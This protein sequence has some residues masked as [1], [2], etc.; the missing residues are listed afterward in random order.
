[1]YSLFSTSCGRESETVLIDISLWG[2]DASNFTRS[3]QQF[4]NQHELWV[5]WLL[6]FY[7]L[8]VISGGMGIDLTC[9]LLVTYSVA[10]L[11]KQT[12]GT[13]TQG[14]IQSHYPDSELTSSCP[15][16]LMPSARLESDKYQFYKSLL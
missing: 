14:P 6:E 13:M 15:I 12:T 8:A 16:L 2:W 1:M 4:I 9:T 5:G 3:C 10:P 7:A 11:G